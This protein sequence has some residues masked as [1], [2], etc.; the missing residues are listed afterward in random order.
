[1][2]LAAPAPY[3]A[4]VARMNTIMDDIEAILAKRK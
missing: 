1:V 4:L 3:Q 2:D